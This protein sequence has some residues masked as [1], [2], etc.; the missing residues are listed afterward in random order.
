MS[1]TDDTAKL[2]A[3]DEDA[4]G[5]IDDTDSLL[6]IPDASEKLARK[7]DSDLQ[8]PGGATVDGLDWLISITTTI[9]KRMEIIEEELRQVKILLSEERKKNGQPGETIGSLLADI[10][11][12]FK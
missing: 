3:L 5:E 2:Y 7:A 6:A 9:D 1:R 4:L 8:R 11:R 10:R 12:R